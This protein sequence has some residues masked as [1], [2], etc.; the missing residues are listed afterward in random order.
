MR[1]G[2]IFLAACRLVNSNIEIDYITIFIAVEIHIR[3]K[4]RIVFRSYGT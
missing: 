1:R 2:V 4:L 3:I